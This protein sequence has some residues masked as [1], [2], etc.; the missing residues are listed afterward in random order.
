[1]QIKELPASTTL[2]SADVFATDASAGATK[3]ITAANLATQV[4]SLGS[5]LGTSEV[6]NNLTTTASGKVLDARQGKTLKDAVDALPQLVTIDSNLLQYARNMT[7]GTYKMFR[8]GGSSYSGSDLPS[9]PY[10]WGVGIILNRFSTSITVVIFA[11]A[12]NKPKC[13]YFDG[14]SWAGWSSMA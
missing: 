5:L 7:E 4:K 11:N 13:N 6:V 1:M 2:T 8:L 9:D 10:K 12:A 14:T 3:K